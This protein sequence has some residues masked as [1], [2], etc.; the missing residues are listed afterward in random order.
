MTAPDLKVL[1]GGVDYGTEKWGN[2]L[3][4]ESKKLTKEL[5]TGYMQLAE[6]LW[7]LYDTPAW[8]DPDRGP[9]WQVF[10]GY[11]SWNDFVQEE[12][13]IH[14]KKAQRLL[15]I[16]KTLSVDLNLHDDVK[17][18]ISALGFSKVR[19]LIRVLTATNYEDWISTAEK[20]GYTALLKSIQEYLLEVQTRQSASRT[21]LPEGAGAE[22]E[23]SAPAYEE[24][25]VPN[26]E[27]DDLQSLHFR[28][29][30]DQADTVKTALKR[31]SELS[32]SQFQSHNLSLICLDFLA[33]N[34][35]RKATEEQ[36]LRYLV[37]F[38]KL[39]GYRLIVIDPEAG[40]KGEDQV[41]YGLATLERLASSP[42]GDE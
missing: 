1:Q 2:K 36:R 35:F 29:Y 24:P 9:V 20:L 14:Y 42:D 11:S 39:L 7:L 40:P 13:G 37:R 8:G 32:N 10:W 3:R 28:L 15:N 38:E 17:V 16:W 21:S 27:N 31:A 33:S 25:P 26:I 5:D 19:E 22:F 34:D 18:R 4:S 41:V 23:P 12:L 30:A 6:R